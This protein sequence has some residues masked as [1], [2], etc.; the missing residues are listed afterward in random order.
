MKPTI[1]HRI[2]SIT[3][4]SGWFCFANAQDQ[5]NNPQGQDLN[6][7]KSITGGLSIRPIF[8]SK[9]FGNG[10]IPFDTA[11]VNFTIN[12]KIS[13]S[14]G[15]VIRRSFTKLLSME[16]GL[17]YTRR[18]YSMKVV[19][20]NN[21]TTFIDYRTIS[22]NFPVQGIV[23]VQLSK[24]VFS[25]LGFGLVFDIYPSDILVKQGVFY[26]VGGLRTSLIGGSLLVNFGF[27]YRT[28]QDGILYLGGSYNRPFQNIYYNEITYDIDGRRLQKGSYLSGSYIALEFRYYLQPSLIKKKEKKKKKG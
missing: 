4:L 22:F 26:N 20:T 25:S 6:P 7:Y 10:S 28:K 24:Q 14:A 27:E 1:F 3:L 2:L 15:A 8:P 5:Q 17:N 21:L 13:Y 9:T 19:D 12:P 11:G 18:V 23:S 16:A